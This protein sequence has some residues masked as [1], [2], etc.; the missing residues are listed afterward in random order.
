MVSTY[1]SDHFSR[2]CKCTFN[3]LVQDWT[4]ENLVRIMTVTKLL[5]EGRTP[6]GRHGIQHDDLSIMTLSIFCSFEYQYAESRNFSNVTLSVVFLSVIMLNVVAPPE[7]RQQQQMSGSLV[8]SISPRKKTDVWMNLKTFYDN[9]RHLRNIDCLSFVMC[10]LLVPVLIV[11]RLLFF[12][13]C[14]G[15]LQNYWSK[16]GRG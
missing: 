5:P 9:H 16:Q 13:F 4:I 1:K 2:T 12:F 6:S 3:Q 15:H 7:W 11:N 14:C 10:R 8:R